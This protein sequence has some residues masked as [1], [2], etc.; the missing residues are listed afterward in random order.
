MMP[1]SGNVKCQIWKWSSNEVLI[2]ADTNQ[3]IWQPLDWKQTHHQAILME[4]NE[5]ERWRSITGLMWQTITFK[6]NLGSF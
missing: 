3:S 5:E 4:D 2:V 1:E 6:I